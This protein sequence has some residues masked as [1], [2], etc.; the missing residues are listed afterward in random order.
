M[1]LPLLCSQ[2]NPRAIH[3]N[4][5]SRRWWIVYEVMVLCFGMP[6]RHFAGDHSLSDRASPGPHGARQTIASGPLLPFFPI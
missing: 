1:S 3:V 2:L 5:L 4:F 6:R